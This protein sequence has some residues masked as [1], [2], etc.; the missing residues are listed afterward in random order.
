MTKTQRFARNSRHPV[1]SADQVPSVGSLGADNRRSDHTSALI[2]S[3]GFQ[4]FGLQHISA[5]DLALLMPDLRAHAG[6][7]R[8]YNCTHIHEPGCSVQAAV[9]RGEIDPHRYE[10]YRSLHAELSQTRY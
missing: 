6:E 1:R 5:A 4:E 9:E 8:F 10:I 7:C 3:P 2:D